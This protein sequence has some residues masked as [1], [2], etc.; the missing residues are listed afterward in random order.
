VEEQKTTQKSHS[1]LSFLKRNGS[2]NA[3]INCI[4]FDSILNRVWQKNGKKDE[5][6][7]E[8]IQFFDAKNDQPKRAK[9]NNQTYLLPQRGLLLSNNQ[10][11]I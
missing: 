4:C 8:F 5:K 9:T 10:P 2:F 7:I 3:T 11:K 1:K 6:F